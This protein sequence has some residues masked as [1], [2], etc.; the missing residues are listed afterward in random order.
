[1]KS[2]EIAR[3]AKRPWTYEISCELKDHA[4]LA[5]VADRARGK[6]KLPK[7][8]I[9][10]NLVDFTISELLEMLPAPHNTK[11]LLYDNRKSY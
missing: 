1:M 9:P 3:Q 10:T 4:S 2:A 11:F 7:M 6:H 8:D 5:K